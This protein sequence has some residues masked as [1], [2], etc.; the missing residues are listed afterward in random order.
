MSKTISQ[1]DYCYHK[2]LGEV[3]ILELGEHEAY[4]GTQDREVYSVPLS[5]L[6]PQ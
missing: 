3:L 6:Y 5:E 4:V 2:E 1:W